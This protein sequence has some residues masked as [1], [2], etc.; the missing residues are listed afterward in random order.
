MLGRYREPVRLWTDPIGHALYRLKLRP[1]HL[2]LAGLGV[3]LLA[4]AAFVAGRTRAAGVLLIF[5]GL[6]D[7]FDGALARASGQVTP[8]GAFL[9][10]VIDR[11]SDLV[12][13]LGIVVL[14]ARM[15]HARGAVVAMAGLV[16]SIMVSYTKAR[17]ES[18]GI[19]C[20]VGVME[21]PERLICLIGGALFDLL[22]PALWVLAILAN[23]TALQ[24]IAFTRRA[25]REAARLILPIV[26]LSTAW[27][28]TAVANS[29]SPRNDRAVPAETERTWADAI[30]AYQRGDVQPLIFEL[31]TEA[32]L[33]G[34]IGDYARFL[35]AEA[36][37]RTGDLA[38]ARS[39]A[40]AV[41]DRYPDSRLAPSALIL[42]ATLAA[43]DGD[44][45]AAQALLKRLV[46]GYPDAGEIPQALYMLAMIGEAGGQLEAAALAY[47]E[48]TVL[49]PASGWADGATDR[50]QAL[51]G[52]GVRL[53]DLTVSQRLE[54][55]ERLLKGGVAKAAAEEAERIAK[56]VRDPG[57]LVRALRV[58]AD[59]SQRLGRFEVAARVLE[60]AAGRVAADRRPS[61]QLEQARL[62]LRASQ[63]ER[64]L[65]VLAIVESTGAEAEAAEAA[66]LKAR[67]LDDL[68]RV[69]AAAA[70]RAVAARHPSRE[71]GGAAL[72]R[73]GWLL[74]LRG[75]VKGAGQT[76]L[77]LTELPG[78]RGLRAPA[79]Y[80]AARAREQTQGRPA[81]EP[82][83]R[84]VIQ[85]APRGYYGML[86]AQ[87]IGAASGEGVPAL[88]E[89][90]GSA[91]RLPADP[92]D[93][94]ADDPGFTRVDLLRR[95]GLVE[96]ALQELGDVVLRSVG[97]PV[98][99]YGLS[100]AYVR[101]ER[102]HLALRILR[103]H[104]AGLAASAPDALPQA[105]WE[106]LYP[107]GWRE[108]V[109]EAADQAGLDR[110]LVAAVVREESSY[111]PRAI[112]RSGA[113][114]L[115]QLMPGTALPM[116]EYRGLAFR[117][118]E[119]LDEPRA[120]LMLGTAFFA[121]LL[122]E[123]GDPYL[124]LAAYNAG[125]KRLRQWWQARRTSDVEAFVEL[126]PYDETRQYVKRVAL[127]W[128]EYRRIYG[129][130]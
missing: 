96:F 107:F 30:D 64:A 114:G 106:M 123:W 41:V 122:R 76:W 2:T 90:A 87:R 16:G 14:F 29:T 101:D 125:P 61:L 27:G 22:E 47:R 97:D 7:F 124:A 38:A 24:R 118:G 12:V 52:A 126:I 67:T 3:S 60:T 40:V 81:A 23:L 21:R 80:W 83:Y 51:A 95:I 44:E 108:E 110:Y 28:T 93:A 57:L 66:L 37:A 36:L 18:I 43:Q 105:F 68:D 49:A 111:Y 17:A 8:F 65:S 48:L 89:G 82:L 109:S 129:S 20:N 19:E 4:A 1:N 15:P 32:A 70:Y 113:R 62:L 34:P 11:Y 63:R 53:P 115:M 77:R 75:D 119:L 103:R 39:Y 84:R 35:V 128:A 104:F 102:Y 120:N 26:V 100:S 45:A 130:R 94:L 58:V 55:A 54:R 99:L 9:D 42:G 13:M 91:L 116:A 69:E 117:D 56:D 79:L 121:G 88:P 86:T 46:A 72:W 74:Y 10:S 6:F 112:S 78:G 71:V 73:L 59:A 127:S 50:V 5:A 92:Y 85:E 33:A 25:T 98:R 31:G